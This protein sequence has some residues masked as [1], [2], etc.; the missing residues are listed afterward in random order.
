MTIE[1]YN[2]ENKTCSPFMKQVFYVLLN[3]EEKDFFCNKTSTHIFTAPLLLNSM[4][5]KNK[6]LAE[7]FKKENK[8][9]KFLIIKVI[10]QYFFEKE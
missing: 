1:N 6:E 5:F 3:K 8:L 4:I 10:P 9:K 2:I 7:K